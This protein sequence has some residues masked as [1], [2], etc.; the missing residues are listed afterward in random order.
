MAVVLNHQGKYYLAEL[1]YNRSL[2]IRQQVLGPSHPDVATSLNNL[3]ALHSDLGRHHEAAK[4]YGVRI[5]LPAYGQTLVHALQML[6]KTPV[7]K[8][9][10]SQVSQWGIF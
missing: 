7:T 8:K 6:R 4:L 5:P 10:L 3:A 1:Y 9:T 2:A